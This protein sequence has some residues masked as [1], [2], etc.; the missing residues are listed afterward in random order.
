MSAV[1][2]IQSAQHA[3]C[4]AVMCHPLPAA[5]SPR[6]RATATRKAITRSRRVPGRRRRHGGARA[7]RRGRWGCGP[8]P[9]G[10]PGVVRE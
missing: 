1:P 7:S 10:K 9:G 6:W 4:S 8:R 5:L 2:T 3:L